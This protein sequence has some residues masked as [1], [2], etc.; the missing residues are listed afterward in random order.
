MRDR[1]FKLIDE[2][3]NLW[4]CIGG[5]KPKQSGTSYVNL[6]SHV[7][8]PHA[9][10]YE[11]HVRDISAGNTVPQTSF[12]ESKVKLFYGSKTQ[13]VY[14][15]LD[16]ILNLLMPFYSCENAV[17]RKYVKHNSISYS[18]FI[19]YMEGLTKIVENKI[20]VLL[21]DKFALGIDGWT[22]SHVHYISM[23]ATFPSKN[24]V[25]P[26]KLLLVFSPFDEEVFQSAAAH[27]SFTE[28]QLDLF[29]KSFKYVVGL[30]GDNCSTNHA[31]ANLPDYPFIGCASHRLNLV[32]TEI[33]SHHSRII[34]QV[35]SIME[36]LRSPTNSAKLRTL[37]NLN[38][39]LSNETRWSSV[40][41][42]LNRYLKLREYLPSLEIPEMKSLLL[43]TAD[44]CPIQV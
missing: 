44:D 32:V 21:P 2:S 14:G 10:L 41:T 39:L 11:E 3:S 7:R 29:G 34:E 6:V 4:E 18:T 19:K 33:L 1:F 40:F 13:N 24:E 37:S 17:L 42:M 43:N 31:F 25:G 22:V 23:Y 36:K 5:K 12:F 8:S 26:R 38:A 27:L 28:F 9:S 35:R 30:I 15:W 16:L 20:Q